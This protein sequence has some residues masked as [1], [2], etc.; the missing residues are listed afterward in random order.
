MRHNQHPN[1]PERQTIKRR[2]DEPKLEIGD[3]IEI[4]DGVIGVVLARYTPSGGRNEIHYIVEKSFSRRNEV[5][6]HELSLCR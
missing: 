4:K 5:W 6:G 2:H 1:D 3:T